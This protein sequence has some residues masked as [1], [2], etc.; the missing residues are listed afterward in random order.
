MEKAELKYQ[1]GD[2]LSYAKWSQDARDMVVTYYFISDYLEDSEEYVIDS[3]SQSLAIHYK[4]SELASY[5]E[6]VKQ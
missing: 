3:F 2:I 5:F 4:A 6:R 1:I